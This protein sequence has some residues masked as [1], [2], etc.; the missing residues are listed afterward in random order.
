MFFEGEGE[1]F[2]PGDAEMLTGDWAIVRVH[3]AQLVSA[4]QDKLEEK[5]KSAPSGAILESIQ[6]PIETSDERNAR[7]VLKHAHL[8]SQARRGRKPTYD[9]PEIRKFVIKLLEHHG[10]PSADDPSLPNQAAIERQIMEYCQ[11]RYG[12]EPAASNIRPKLAKWLTEF[13]KERS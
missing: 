7:H 9:W 4:L 6:N 1:V 13:K 5:P 8:S 10:L 12:R 2:I 3:R 11:L